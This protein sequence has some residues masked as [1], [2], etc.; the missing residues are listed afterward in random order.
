MATV[1]VA[2]MGI[3]VSMGI[4]PGMVAVSTF[5]SYCIGHVQSPSDTSHLRR[6][7]IWFLLKFLCKVEQ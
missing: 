7:Y 6:Y 2:S 5:S 3:G 4:S 1:G